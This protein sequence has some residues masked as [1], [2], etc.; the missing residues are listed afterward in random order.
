MTYFESVGVDYQYS[1][2]NIL[3][4][5]KSFAKSCAK[6]S[7]QGKHI[8]CKDCAIAEAYHNVINFVIH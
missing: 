8:S 5:K 6:C 1:A 2:T 7:I 4:A 3:E